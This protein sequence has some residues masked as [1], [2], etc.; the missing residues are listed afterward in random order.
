MK[1]AVLSLLV[2]AVTTLSLAACGES[3]TAPSGACGVTQ[4]S[5][6]CK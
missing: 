1:R 3:P 4:G 5:E 2:L 6:T